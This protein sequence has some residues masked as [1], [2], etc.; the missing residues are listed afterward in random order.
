MVVSQIK[1]LWNVTNSGD[2]DHLTVFQTELHI[3]D[4]VLLIRAYFSQIASQKRSAFAFDVVRAEHS[5]WFKIRQ[6]GGFR[7][8]NVSV[9]MHVHGILITDLIDHFRPKKL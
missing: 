6:C 5:T 3:Y 1:G 9:I 7:S 2:E 8:W 4:C